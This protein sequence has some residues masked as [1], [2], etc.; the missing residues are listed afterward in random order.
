MAETPTPVDLFVTCIVDA[1]YP[2]V[3][4]ATVSVLEALGEQVHLPARQTCCGLP[5]YNN[6]YHDEARKVARHTLDVMT[7]DVPVVV[8]S[9]SCAWMLRHVYPELF[10]DGTPEHERA[11]AFAARVEELSE[12]VALRMTASQ[13][14]LPVPLTA[15]YHAS[16]HLL[17]GLRV[18]TPPHALLASVAN[19]EVRRME[20]ETECCGFGG[21]FAAR[22]GDVS[23][24]ILDKKLESAKETKASLVVLNDAGCM[25]Q[26]DGGAKRQGCD[27]HVCHIAEL[28]AE[29]LA[30]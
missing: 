8:P 28:L 26:I 22:Y 18:E 10:P 19:L 13:F 16:C 12:H 29:A 7:D 21:T 27:F 5:L 9:G 23:S 24:A 1:V 17:R 4:E 20:A 11:T 30:R 25:L 14:A 6:G 3:G 2:H 15:T